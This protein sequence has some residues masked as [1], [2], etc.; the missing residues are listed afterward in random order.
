MLLELFHILFFFF[1]AFREERYN[2]LLRYIVLCIVVFSSTFSLLPDGVDGP[3]HSGPS[4]GKNV[5]AIFMMI[6]D[7]R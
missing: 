2:Y 3:A 5:L 6:T 1:Y 4:Q 7:S